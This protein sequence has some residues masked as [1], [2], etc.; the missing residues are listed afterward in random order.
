[1]RS[2]LLL[3]VV[4]LVLANS[5]SVIIN[6]VVVGNP[7]LWL[8]THGY[9]YQVLSHDPKVIHIENFLSEVEC[10]Y[11]VF[12]AKPHV[13]QLVIFDSTGEQ[14]VSK[15][16]TSKGMFVEHNHNNPLIQSLEKRFKDLTGFQYAES[17]QIAHYGLGGEYKPHYDF[18][19]TNTESGKKNAESY[20][21]RL[22][23]GLVYLNAPEEGGNTIFPVLD[24]SVKPVKGCA[25]LFYNVK[26]NGDVDSRTLHGGAPVIAG[27]K[28]IMNRWFH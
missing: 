4:S 1:M 8:L 5:E 7:E 2:L 21:Q 9:T 14:K 25:I 12:N 24:I 19:D 6:G 18:H 11:M 15:I 20:G 16:R 26:A 27:E 23:T 10:D 3:L 22:A 13:H 28:W 17:L